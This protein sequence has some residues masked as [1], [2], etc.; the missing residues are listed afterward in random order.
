MSS[1]K[2][3]HLNQ[4]NAKINAIGNPTD[5]KKRK[6]KKNYQKKGELLKDHLI[7]I[8]D[9]KVCELDD[10]DFSEPFLQEV[11]TEINVPSC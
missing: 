4:Y 3:K 10:L 9:G 7:Y 11:I 5:A 1:D 6:E 8:Q 2:Q